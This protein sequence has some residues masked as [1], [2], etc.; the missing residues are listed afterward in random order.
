MIE[1]VKKTNNYEFFRCLF[2]EV[3]PSLSSQFAPMNSPKLQLGRFE[4]TILHDGSM[5]FSPLSAFSP[6]ADYPLLREFLRQQNLPEDRIVL[7]NN[8]PLVR[9]PN[10]WI[11]IDGGSGA[12]FSE[13]TGTLLHNL[14]AN[15]V[16]PD[17]INA[18]IITHAHPDH[19]WGLMTQ[20]Q[21]TFPNASYFLHHREW[22]FWSDPR[23]LEKY[24]ESKHA[25]IRGTQ[26]VFR[27]LGDK[28]QTVPD[29]AHVL[30]GFS[31][32]DTPGHTPGHCGVMI[33][34]DGQKAL[35]LGD[36]LVHPWISFR[37]PE[38]IFVHD[39][40]P[41]QAQKARE[42]ILDMGATDSLKILGFH[43][44]FPGIGTIVRH[45]PFYQWNPAE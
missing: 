7:S 24:P 31:L 32:V 4:I 8:I 42:R 5:E 23:L 40:N 9:T 28:I 1:I 20:Q 45:K 12:N 16:S 27:L 43:L 44:P 15:G 39:V 19:L 26:E 6:N 3:N 2:S 18:V 35:C 17:M 41:D 37:Y 22:D 21:E 34:S 33:E 38:W 30:P 11:L 10:Q 14:N 29:N 25:F 36:T 13:T